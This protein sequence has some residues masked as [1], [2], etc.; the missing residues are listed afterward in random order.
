[1]SPD[2]FNSL[3]GIDIFFCKL[4]YEF[5]RLLLTNILMH[6]TNKNLK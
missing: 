2:K 3:T 4:I 1:M 5:V 6:Y